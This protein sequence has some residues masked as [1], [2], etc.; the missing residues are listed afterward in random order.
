VLVWTVVYTVS[1]LRGVGVDSFVD[2]L[3]D[4]SVLVMMMLVE[5][6]I[7]CTFLQPISIVLTLTRLLGKLGQRKSLIE[8]QSLSMTSQFRYVAA[9]L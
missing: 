3:Q 5:I 6:L 1:E 9:L 2:C 7:S 8:K 4:L